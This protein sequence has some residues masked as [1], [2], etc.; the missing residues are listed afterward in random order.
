MIYVVTFFALVERRLY[1]ISA[2]RDS[3]LYKNL[4]SI[5]KFAVC[6]QLLIIVGQHCKVD[7][8]VSYDLLQLIAY[9]FDGLFFLIAFFIGFIRGKISNMTYEE[10][11]NQIKYKR[12][13]KK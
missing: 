5:L 3:S 2:A 1:D 6:F 8:N 12:R 13:D 10:Y 7:I 11:K 4:S 9:L